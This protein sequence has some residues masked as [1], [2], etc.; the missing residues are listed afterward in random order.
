MDFWGIMQR[1]RA[2]QWGEQQNHCR[3]WVL[4][5]VSTQ[6]IGFRALPH[7]SAVAA[8]AEPGV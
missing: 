1:Q 6:Q 3:L 8:G 4:L 2:A 5:C 7:V